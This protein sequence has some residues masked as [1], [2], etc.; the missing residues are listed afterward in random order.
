[1]NDFPTWGYH[2]QLSFLTSIVK[3]STQMQMEEEMFLVKTK[4][5]H[6]LKIRVQKN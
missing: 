3:I 6:N 2:T 4:Q 5:D 1:M